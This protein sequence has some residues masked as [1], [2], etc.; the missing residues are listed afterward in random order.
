M[1]KTKR[2]VTD[3]SLVSV[4]MCTFNGERFIDEQVDSIIKQDYKHIELIVI[5]DHSGDS[6]WA[7]L[8]EWKE[9]FPAIRLFRNEQNIGYN[10]NFQKAISLATGDLIAISDQDDIW[11]PQKISRLMQAFTS[12]GIILAHCRSVRFEEGRLRYSLARL[13]HH[14]KGNDTRKLFMFN[15][16]MGHDM[17]FRKELVPCILPVP[18]GMSYDWWIGVVATTVGEVASVEEYLVYHRIHGQ[19]NFFSQ[20]GTSEKKKEFDLPDTL[21][22]FLQISTLRSADREFLN[23]FIGLLKRR[24]NTDHSFDAKLFR[25]LFQHRRVFFGHK[26]RWIPEISYVK[27]AI[28]YA[29]K[30]FSGKGMSI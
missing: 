7:K 12:P 13:H 17:L 21:Q 11:L 29:R 30:N 5:D 26:R 25:F 27:S 15:Q 28:R 3:R 16:M 10:G 4:V 23:T 8:N 2:M 14:F 19:N 20:P 24:S 6:T 18:E 9:K 1:I 22:C